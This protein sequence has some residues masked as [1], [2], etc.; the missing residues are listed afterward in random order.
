MWQPFLDQNPSVT[1]Q[2][3][4]TSSDFW[5]L[6]PVNVFISGITTSRGKVLELQW[7]LVSLPSANYYIALY[8]QDNRSPSAHSWRIFDVSINNQTFFSKLNVTTSGLTV[9]STQWQLSGQ[10]KITL[11][12]REGSPVGPVINAGEILLILPLGGQTIHRDGIL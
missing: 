5:N 2:S 9:Y 8:F 3:N 10:T 1:S 7:P 11:I 4:V 6:P 12:P